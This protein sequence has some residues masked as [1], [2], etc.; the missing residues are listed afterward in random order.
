[1]IKYENT[2]FDR[3]AAE[4]SYMQ[5]SMI[6]DVNSFRICIACLSRLSNDIKTHTKK[7]LYTLR[8]SLNS[9]KKLYKMI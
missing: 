9:K 1:M 8:R 4:R 2:L 3:G 6:P 7:C 5:Q